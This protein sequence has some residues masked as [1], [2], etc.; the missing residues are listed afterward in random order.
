MERRA[1]ILASSTALAYSTFSH[2]GLSAAELDAWPNSS[3][4]IGL[5]HLHV[6]GYGFG[7][8]YPGLAKIRGI[9]VQYG[10]IF[11]ALWVHW[12]NGQNGARDGGFGGHLKTRLNFGLDEYL[13]GAVI[14]QGYH[15]NQP[16]TVIK[17][18]YFVTNKRS[19]DTYGA[20]G[21]S[22]TVLAAP[23]GFH[24]VGFSGWVGNEH[25]HVT[26]LNG[27]CMPL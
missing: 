21:D 2:R 5:K 20:G 3:V 11:E 24:L 19:T 22:A 17:S 13:T 1:F 4:S 10:T 26:S 23:P 16:P 15:Q 12:D 18:I 7:D 27:R 9:T 25:G 8:A 6:D 14:T